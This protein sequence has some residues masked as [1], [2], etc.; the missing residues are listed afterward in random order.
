MTGEELFR[1][2]KQSEAAREIL[3]LVVRPALPEL[4]FDGQWY[5]RC[6]Y[7]HLRRGNSSMQIEPP[8]M[9]VTWRVADLCPVKVEYLERGEPLG[10][11]RDMLDAQFD[12]RQKEYLRMCTA[13]LAGEVQYDAQRMHKAWLEAQPQA[14]RAW[15]ED[16][17]GKA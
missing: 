8:E 7:Y 11:V 12:R 4:Y 3:P 6:L 9:R 1:A 14:L 10:E 5:A 15:V 16:G 17:E 13:L 2:V